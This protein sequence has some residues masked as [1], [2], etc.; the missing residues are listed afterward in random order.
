M[1]SEKSFVSWFRDSSPYI[2]AHRKKTF[3]ISFGGEAVQADDFDHH[4]HDIALLNSLGIRLVIVHGI[5]PQID[6]RLEKLNTPALFHKNLRITDDLALQCVKE[7]AGLVRVEIEALLSMGLSNSPMAGS[8]LKVVSGNYIVAKPIGVIDGIDYCHTGE[9]RRIDSAAIHQQLDQNTVVLISPIGYSLSGEIFNL[10]AEQV[11]TA[12]SIA[13]KAEKL[14]LLTEH[15]YCNPEDGEQIRQMTTVETEHFLEHHKDISDLTKLPLKAAMQSCQAG[16]ERVHLIDRH[17]DG[18]LLQE[19]FSRDGIGTLVSSAPFEVLRS[20]KLDDI[21]G[22]LELIKPLEKQ[23]ILVKRSREKIEME[24]ADYI[25]LERDGLIIA[26]AAFY[27]NEHDYYGVIA[28]LAVHANYQGASRGARLLSY[29][30]QKA[31]EMKLKTL[32]VLSTQTMQWFIERGFIVS[33]IDNLPEPL[34][35]L[36]NP[37]RNS[38]ILRKDIESKTS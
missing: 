9:V 14:I 23:G 35:A 37:E 18:A 26:C 36:Y 22:I 30:D 32:F 1:Q 34:K 28:S 5:R 16:I 11:A 31:L 7:A 4:I 21:G 8:S 20:A 2:H 19:L 12:V 10:S 13:L 25:V 24:I 29:V 6:Q 27:A 15:S 38:K 3:V 17:I 33:D